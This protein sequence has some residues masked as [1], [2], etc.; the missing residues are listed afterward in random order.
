MNTQELA[1]RLFEEGCNPYMYAIGARGAASDAFCLSF[2]GA[3]WEVYYTERGIDDPPIFVSG[4][5]A[6]ACDFFFRHIMGLRHEHCVGFF[7]SEQ[8]AVA[9]HHSLQV[10]GL[11]ARQDRIPYGGPNDPRFR[12]FVTGKGIFTE[13]AALGNVPVRDEGA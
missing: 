10:L 12:V 9:L 13:R 11:V 8:N 5:E 6:Q 1:Q 4:S 7:R 2:N 3:Q